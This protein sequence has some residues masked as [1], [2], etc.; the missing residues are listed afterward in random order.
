MH[1][2]L[3]VTNTGTLGINSAYCRFE[4][5]PYELKV[6]FGVRCGRV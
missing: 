4:S 1:S 2:T 6:E 5:L 3:Y